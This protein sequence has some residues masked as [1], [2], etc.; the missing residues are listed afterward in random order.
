MTLDTKRKLIDCPLVIFIAYA[1]G[2][3]AEEKGY[4]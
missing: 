2:P 3:T 4:S 1:V